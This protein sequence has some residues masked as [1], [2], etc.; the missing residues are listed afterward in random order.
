MANSS[1]THWIGGS[2]GPRAGL[3]AVEKIKIFLLWWFEPQ[4]SSSKPIAIPNAVTILLPYMAQYLR[5]KTK[6]TFSSNMTLPQNSRRRS[7][8]CFLAGD[9]LC[10]ERRHS[11]H[12]RKNKIPHSSTVICGLRHSSRFRRW[13]QVHVCL[14]AQMS[15]ARMILP[16]EQ[17]ISHL[18]AHRETTWKMRL[19]DLATS[20]D[21][22]YLT[23][24]RSY[25]FNTNRFLIASWN[26]ELL[27]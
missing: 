10:C 14:S 20:S 22:P 23:S 6:C 8:Y 24:T 16:H 1:C 12:A 2:V 13:T 27:Q 5:C 26:V 7:H 17:T 15:Y 9:R 19:P 4:P 25:A 21:L 18:L 3:V 11:R